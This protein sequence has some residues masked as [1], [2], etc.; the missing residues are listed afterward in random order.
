VQFHGKGTWAWT[1]PSDCDSRK[2]Y[3][4]KVIV[5]PGKVRLFFV[6]AAQRSESELMVHGLGAPSS[7]CPVVRVISYFTDLFLTYMN[8]TY[9][10]TYR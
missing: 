7:A 3:D 2:R 10:C 1:E 6:F 4:G 5:W 8:M 9:P